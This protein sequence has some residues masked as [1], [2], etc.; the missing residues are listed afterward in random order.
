MAYGASGVQGSNVQIKG[1]AIVSYTTLDGVLSIRE[2]GGSSSD[3]NVTP[4]NSAA[5]VSIP[6][7]ADYGSIE[8][9]LAYDP[10]DTV[11]KSL[12]TAFGSATVSGKRRD[13]KWTYADGTTTNSST[14]YL[15]AT[16]TKFEVTEQ[17]EDALKAS[18]TLKINAVPVEVAGT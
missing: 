5:K 17:S 2:S 9:E 6:G 13:L 8:M 14:E 1:G 18:V 3:I 16:V 11:H 4:I 15:A 10:K 7:F 12:R